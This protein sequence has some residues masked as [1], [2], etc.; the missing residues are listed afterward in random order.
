MNR[1][2]LLF[3][4]AFE[5]IYATFDGL[6]ACSIGNSEMCMA[7][8]KD[9]AWNN[10]KVSLDGGGYK[11][12]ISTP[13]YLRKEIKCPTGLYDMVFVFQPLVHRISFFLIASNVFAEVS[14]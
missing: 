6:F 3:C 9:T 11:F 8:G 2:S 1:D 7:F 12:L 10:E 13:G 5:D 4:K 14:F